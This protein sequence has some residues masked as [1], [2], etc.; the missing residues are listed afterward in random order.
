MISMFDVAIPVLM[1]KWIINFNFSLKFLPCF[2]P[3]YDAIF[4]VTATDKIEEMLRIQVVGVNKFNKFRNF[5]ACW[6]YLGSPD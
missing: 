6:G 1:C 5:E 3:R 4:N 2:D